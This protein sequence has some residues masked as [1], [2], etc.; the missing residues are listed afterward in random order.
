MVSLGPVPMPLVLLIVS[1]AIAAIVGRA[2][3]RAPGQPPVPLFS[4]FF[5]ML[6]VGLIA[7]RLVFVL[8]YLPLYR[9]D[10]WSVIRP[11]DG[12]YS[13]WA[14]ILAGLAFG[15]WRARRNEALRRPLAWGTVAGLGAWA[16]LAGTLTLLEQAHI[17]L[18]EMQL[19]RLEGG[20]IQLSSLTGRPV[21]VNLWATWC[22][23]CRREMPALAEGEHAHPDVTFVFVNQG[24]GAADVRNYL[25]SESLQLQNVVLDPFS[26]V[27][28]ATGARGLPTTLFFAHDGRLVDTH[29]GELTRAS[30]AHKLQRLVADPAPPRGDDSTPR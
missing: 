15:A 6:L 13:I 3:A 23:P 16:V 9:D 18:P 27:S 1:V 7:G 17:R 24:E 29:V 22:P 20:P 10:P 26:A 28:Q 30:L 19:T 25:R 4:V 11:G 5:D 2:V 21:V 14:A 8:Q 12:G